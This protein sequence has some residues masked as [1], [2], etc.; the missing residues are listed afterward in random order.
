MERYQVLIYVTPATSPLPP[1]PHG[2]SPRGSLILHMGQPFLSP[3]GRLG[4]E[5]SAPRARQERALTVELSC[6]SPC[7]SPCPQAR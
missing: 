2:V 1:P 3:R 6:P 7:P 4:R 5:P